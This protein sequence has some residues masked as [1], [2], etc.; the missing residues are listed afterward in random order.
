MVYIHTH[1]MEYYLAF[2]NKRILFYVTAWMSLEDIMLS[3]MNSHRTESRMAV[4]SAS[5]E[6]K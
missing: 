3:E 6:G 5:R 2:K 1:T 4:A